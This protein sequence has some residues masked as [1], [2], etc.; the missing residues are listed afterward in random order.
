VSI[1]IPN[2]PEAP[3]GYTGSGD[4]IDVQRHLTVAFIDTAPIMITLIPRARAKQPAGGYVYQELT[5][6][7]PQKFR[8]V[9]PYHSGSLPVMLTG[10]DGIQREMELMLLGR[11]DCDLEK[12]DIF[13]HDGQRYEVAQLNFS[14]GWEQR[15]EVIRFG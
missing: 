3:S 5:P 7:D 1:I 2:P 9:E 14:N 10:S 12:Y 8:L 15:A 13:E 11:W 4:E 6:R